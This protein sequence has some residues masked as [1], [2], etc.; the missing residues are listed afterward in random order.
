MSIKVYSWNVC[1]GCMLANENSEADKT[2][3]ELGL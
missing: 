1:F 2:A 3:K